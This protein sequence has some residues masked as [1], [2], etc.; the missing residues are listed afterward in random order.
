M[1]LVV[2]PLVVL[3]ALIFLVYSLASNKSRN[4]KGVATEST[5]ST[6]KQGKA[7]KGRFSLMAI[8]LALGLFLVLLVISQRALF[9]LNRYLNPVIEEEQLGKEVELI[10]SYSK[11]TT[12]GE[13]FSEQTLVGENVRVL[14]PK[15]EQ[16]RYLMWKLI[17]HGTAIGSLVILT[18]SWYF[19]RKENLA[20]RPL[21]MGFLAL[22]IWMIFQ[23]LG[24]VVAFI[25]R[26]YPGLSLYLFWGALAVL[27]GFLAYRFQGNVDSNSSEL[28]HS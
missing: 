14:Y 2:V 20:S 24:E 15:T 13:M 22:S 21:M 3:I 11:R 19:T 25:Q 6:K 9:D 28:S 18:L 5:E 16:E 8:L 23:L 10:N 17:I 7:K 4:K 27:L 26:A 12:S 1:Y